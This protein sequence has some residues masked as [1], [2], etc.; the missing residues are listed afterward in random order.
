[1]ENHLATIPLTQGKVALIDDA[2]LDLVAP[3]KWHAQLDCSR[4]YAATNVLGEAGGYKSVRLH[5][6]LMGPSGGAP[7]DHR[8]GD[9]LD[10][11]RQNLRFAT[12]AENTYNQGPKANNTSGFKGVSRAHGKWK[13]AI[14][15]GGQQHYLG[16]FVTPEQAALAYDSG[17]RELH[18]EFARTNF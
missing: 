14:R 10:N 7:I 9:G 18:G 12:P 4:C 11:R 2:D 5:R 16:V 17:A 8:S 6:L 13:A 1:L 15:A 3:Y